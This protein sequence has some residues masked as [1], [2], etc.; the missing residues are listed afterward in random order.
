MHC[1]KKT[2]ACWSIPICVN[3]IVLKVITK[4]RTPDIG[5][6]SS[7][8]ANSYAVCKTSVDFCAVLL[9]LH[10]FTHSFPYG[11]TSTLQHDLF[12]VI[13]GKLYNK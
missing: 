13:G 9:K 5:K 7:A 1:Y 8:C 4:D 3:T 6:V 12:A 2:T 10:V 11:K